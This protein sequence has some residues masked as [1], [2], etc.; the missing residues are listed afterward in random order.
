MRSLGE[1]LS[2]LSSHDRAQWSQSAAQADRLDGLRATR[3]GSEAD[4]TR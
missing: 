3:A 1:A 4:E 2:Q